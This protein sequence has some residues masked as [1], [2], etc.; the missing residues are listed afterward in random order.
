[1]ERACFGKVLAKNLGNVCKGIEYIL[2]RDYLPSTKTVI[3]FVTTLS[4]FV[5]LHV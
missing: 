4:A 1:M 5:A 2:R 3:F